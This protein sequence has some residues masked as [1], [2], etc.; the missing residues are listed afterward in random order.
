[1]NFKNYVSASYNSFLKFPR[2]HQADGGQPQKNPN[3]KT[4]FDFVKATCSYS[5]LCFGCGLYKQ[6]RLRAEDEDHAPVSFVIFKVAC[7]ANPTETCLFDSWWGCYWMCLAPVTNFVSGKKWVMLSTCIHSSWNPQML[8][9]L[10]PQKHQIN[11][12]SEPPNFPRNFAKVGSQ[13]PWPIWFA[14]N[15]RNWEGSVHK[16][17]QL[18][19][20]NPKI[21]LKWSA[22]I[23]RKSDLFWGRFEAQAPRFV[24]QQNVGGCLNGVHTHAWF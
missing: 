11:D 17:K 9:N 16:Q 14:R 18:E 21:E 12:T 19:P 24:N 20:P 10:E 2:K 23:S 7:I 13:V 6:D 15:L 22:L 1:M 3:Q 5:Y 8:S 4:C